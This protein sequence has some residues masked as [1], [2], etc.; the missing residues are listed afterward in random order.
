VPGA[1]NPLAWNRYAYTLYNP[2]RYVD[3]SGNIPILD[4][5]IYLLKFKNRLFNEDNGIFAE[6]DKNYENNSEEIPIDEDEVNYEL[7]DIIARIEEEISGS[8]D[9]IPEWVEDLLEFLQKHPW[10]W[11]NP[12]PWVRDI[13]FVEEAGGRRIIMFDYHPLKPG[14][15]PV[16]HLNSELRILQGV[17]HKDITPYVIA[18]EQFIYSVS[19]YL[20]FFDP[21][22]IFYF[23][24]N[25]WDEIIPVPKE[26]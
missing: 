6:I 9:T 8:T 1:G 4:I 19:P 12:P 15:N 18:L 17:N 11:K 21:L 2:L 24:Y 23:P 25:I 5:E 3:P 16:W 22:P 26:T 7:E 20:P 10:I 14:G 13:L